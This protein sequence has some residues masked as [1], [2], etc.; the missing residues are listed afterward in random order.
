MLFERKYPRDP[1]YHESHAWQVMKLADMLRMRAKPDT[2][3]EVTQIIPSRRVQ[4]I[5]HKPLVYMRAGV[6]NCT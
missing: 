6:K 4:N 2:Y 5:F 1:Y 3:N